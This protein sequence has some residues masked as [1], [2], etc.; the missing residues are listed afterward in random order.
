MSVAVA[1][2]SVAVASPPVSAISMSSSQLPFFGDFSASF[3]F[4]G[5]SSPS[6]FPPP[7]LAMGSSALLHLFFNFS[8]GICRF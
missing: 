2:L 1:S 7:L 6:S 8:S 4:N 3:F 5:S